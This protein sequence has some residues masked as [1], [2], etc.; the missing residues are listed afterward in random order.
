MVADDRRGDGGEQGRALRAR[1]RDRRRRPRHRHGARLRRGAR[2]R[3]CA[4][5]GGRSDDGAEHRGEGLP[6]RGRRL[7]RAAL[8]H[9]A[10][11]GG[12]GGQGQGRRSTTTTWSA[13]LQAMAKGIRDRGKATPGEKTMIDA[14]APAAEA[15]AAARA[16]GQRPGRLPRRGGRGGAGRARR[17]RGTWS[18][19][20][21]RAERLGERAV[22]PRRSGRR[23]GGRS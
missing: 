5:A 3:R 14:W 19:R 4:R 8:R 2:R 17:R 15:A 20:K 13:M 23:L 1:R 6:Q 11:A 22:G 9:R 21:G 18:R 16:R 7:V 12:R 10:D